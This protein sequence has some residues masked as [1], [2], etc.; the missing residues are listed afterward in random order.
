LPA[1]ALVAGRTVKRNPSGRCPRPMAPSGD[2][3]PVSGGGF[4]YHA[5]TS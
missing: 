4:R 2:G 5:F 3:R 1:C